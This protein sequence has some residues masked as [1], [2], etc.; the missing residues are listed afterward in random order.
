VPSWANWFDANAAKRNSKTQFA[1]VGIVGVLAMNDEITAEKLMKSLENDADYRHRRAE[2]EGKF[3]RLREKYAELD[4]PILESLR[5][6]G[7]ES[8]SI[9]EVTRK[10][11]PLPE[12]I[13]EVLLDSLDHCADDRM[14]ES[15]VRAIGASKESFDGRPLVNRF[16]QTP[17]EALRWA[18]INTIALRKP[19]SIESWLESARNDPVLGKA[20]RDLAID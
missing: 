13:V 1:V 8:N 4:R 7:F 12:A 2:R 16:H 5:E 6:L 3:R 11:T 14:C 17:D 9:D 18:I 15:I 19:H 10:F 20:L